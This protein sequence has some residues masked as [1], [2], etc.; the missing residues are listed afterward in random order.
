MH[1][2]N[3]TC[4]DCGSANPTWT[5]IT[6]GIFICLDCSAAHRALGVHISV[7][8]SAVLDANWTWLYLR[9]MQLGGN[10]KLRAYFETHMP[11]SEGLIN[12]IA[13]K[14]ATLNEFKSFSPSSSASLQRRRYDNR[15]ATIYATK[16][17]NLTELVNRKLGTEQIFLDE[18]PSPDALDSSVISDSPRLIANQKQTLNVSKSN[19]KLKT[20]KGLGAVRVQPKITEPLES[21]DDTSEV[22]VPAEDILPDQKYG[23]AMNSQCLGNIHYSD[24]KNKISIKAI[25]TIAYDEEATGSNEA[26]TEK[27]DR[28]GIGASSKGRPAIRA[29]GAIQSIEQIDLPSKQSVN[30]IFGNESFNF[31]KSEAYSRIKSTDIP[32]KWL[33]VKSSKFDKSYD[34]AANFD[35]LKY[36]RVP[37]SPE[38]LDRH[39]N[40][41]ERS[42]SSTLT[43]SADAQHRFSKAKAISSDQYFGTANQASGRTKNL[44][45]F[46]DSSAI[47]SADLFPDSNAQ[48][49]QRNRNNNNYFIPL[50]KSVENLKQDLKLGINTVTD[51][52]YN[53]AGTVISSMQP[54]R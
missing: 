8:R 51:H 18:L 19:K 2:A 5:S 46:H 41:S 17:A 48:Q 44:S 24:D 38:F 4:F 7:V 31:P 34:R 47:S 54:K 25:D 21:V 33:D 39:S 6:F 50:P 30:D 13:N 35:A 22:K 3:K 49:A 37:R 43:Q 36:S 42:T 23:F 40:L 14:T 27:F 16:L 52:M 53:I 1:S 15:I 45:S 10:D 20:K 9:S 29:Y 12:E 26:L 28:L 11:D 32:P